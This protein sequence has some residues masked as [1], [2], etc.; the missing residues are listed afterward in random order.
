MH[1]YVRVLSSI[2]KQKGSIEHISMK[3]DEVEFILTEVSKSNPDWV[4]VNETLQSFPRDEEYLK[5]LEEDYRQ[6]MDR[7][8][9]WDAEIQDV[10][11]LLTFL[12][13]MFNYFTERRP[14]LI[15]EVESYLR[16]SNM[17]GA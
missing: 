17:S 7:P 6:L 2:A 14:E 4:R 9:R 3:L 8:N 1:G 10:K 15:S 13:I 5:P 11:Q 16:S 12:R